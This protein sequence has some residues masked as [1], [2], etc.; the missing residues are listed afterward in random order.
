LV[1]PEKAFS[2]G[3]L[4]ETIITSEQAKKLPRDKKSGA[5]KIEL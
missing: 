4:L 1:A 2:S 5:V 3:D